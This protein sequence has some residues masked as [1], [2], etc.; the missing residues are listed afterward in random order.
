[1]TISSSGQPSPRAE[2]IEVLLEQEFTESELVPL[3]RA[4]T[5][6]GDTEGLSAER[7]DHLA[8][9]AYELATNAVRHGGGRGRLRLWKA[10]DAIHCQVTDEGLG[11]PADHPHTPPT[12]D[13]GAVSG[14]GLWLALQL[15]D[16]LD[17]SS[18]PTGATITA[19]LRLK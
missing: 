9:V 16:S 1:M 5:A 8:L 15:S 10:D 14:R 12:P 7:V 19:T 2:R 17:L 11:L 6:H 3:R 13:V 18:G 4:V